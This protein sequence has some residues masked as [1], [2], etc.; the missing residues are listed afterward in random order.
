MKKKLKWLILVG[1]FAIVGIQFIP[2]VVNQQESIP[3][4]DIRYVY[5]MPDNVMRTLESSCYDCHSNNTRYPWYSRL[6]PIRFMMDNHVDE[7]KGELN[8][9][10]FANYSDRRKISKLSAVS[11]QIKEQEMP[12]PSYLLLHPEATITKQQA[13]S[14]FY[15]IEKILI[16]NKDEK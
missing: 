7:G 12:L 11:E 6:Q 3:E 9:N 2:T 8:F 10:E 13:D 14:I 4:T 5:G 15:V 16:E 1:L